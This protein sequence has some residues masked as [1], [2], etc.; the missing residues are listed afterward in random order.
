V[1][2]STFNSASRPLRLR[3]H[4]GAIDQRALTNR[5]PIELMSDLIMMVRENGMY[6]RQSN[7]DSTSFKLKIVRPAV[8]SEVKPEVEGVKPVNSGSFIRNLARL[9]RDFFSQ[10]RYRTKYGTGYNKGFNE[11]NLASASVEPKP[12]ADLGEIKFYI[13]SR[14]SFNTCQEIQKIKNLAGLYVIEFKRRQGDIWEFKRL[15]TDLLPKMKLEF[16]AV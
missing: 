12:I 3:F 11:T 13:V 7:S 5:A 10:M 6:V 2:V 16:A 8:K 1:S 9:P 14:F 15:Y 4:T